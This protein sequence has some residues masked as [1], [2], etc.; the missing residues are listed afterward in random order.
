MPRAARSALRRASLAVT[1]GLLVSACSSSGSSPAAGSGTPNASR[2]SAPLTVNSTLEGHAVLPHRIHW[3]ALPSVPG[4]DVAEVDFLI[5][6]QVFWVEHNAPYYYGGDD[7]YLVTSF[8][9]PGP[10]TFT[11]KVITAADQSATQTVTA[12]VPVAPAPPAALTG[13]WWTFQSG[14]PSG[15][16]SPPAGY[17]RLVVS[18]ADWR[19][20]DT[21]GTGDTLD[22]IYPAPGV[23]VFQT[24]MATGHPMFGTQQGAP[25][26]LDLNGWCNNDPGSPVRYHWSVTAGRLSL[27]YVTGQACQGFNGFMTSAWSRTR[28]R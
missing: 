13:T 8:L 7:N 6:G 3:Q 26:A 9:T 16:G 14:G 15:S 17:W 5:D 19:I 23:L 11:V 12:T 22:V 27:Q 20:Y 1:L 24:G 28:T 2:S 25:G 18:S 10:H 4:A 21:A